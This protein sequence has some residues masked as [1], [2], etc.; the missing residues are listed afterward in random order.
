MCV[1]IDVPEDKVYTG[2]R[3]DI[4]T[5]VLDSGAPS[6]TSLLRDSAS[7]LITDNEGMT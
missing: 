2:D 4:I 7:L 6:D 5:V 1:D 3:T